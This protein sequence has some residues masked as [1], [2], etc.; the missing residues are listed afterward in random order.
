V[1]NYKI[2]QIVL[3]LAPFVFSFAFGLDIYIP[4]V[5]Q[6]IE[7]FDTSPAMVHL[8]LS[9]F[10]CITGLGQL[11]IGPLSDR[12]GRK[13]TFYLSSICYV[14][15]S[16][17]CALSPH[18]AWLILGRLIC[19]F[20]ACGLLVTSFALI[21]DLYS[22]NDSARMYSFLNGAIGISPT[23]API[24]GGYLSIYLGWQSIFIFLAFIGVLTFFVTW[25]FIGETHGE[26]K[27]IPLDTNI[28]PRYWM[29]FRNRQF[30]L[31]ATIA[32]LAEGVF[33]CFFSI[34]P[35][36]IIDLLG[37]ETQ[38][39]G[40][41][42]AIFGLVIALGGFASGKMIARVGIQSTI[43]SGIIL[44]IAGG[45]CMLSWD[46]F[47]GLSLTGFLF[48]M[49]LACTGAIFAV[50]ACAS[51]ALEPFAPIAGTAAAALGAFE[52]SLS[53]I[54]GALLMLFPVSSTAPY[55][56][57]IVLTGV[58]AFILF[59]KANRIVSSGTREAV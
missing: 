37:I 41:Y 28:F 2:Y 7:I 52:F 56:V 5:P 59:Q 25:R 35:F 33:F 19:G 9:L 47:A 24:I 17:L 15:G 12:Y 58:S 57:I 13:I 27:R 43:F 34:S 44:I 39:F 3:I 40:Y 6:M 4:V 55:G 18:I 20:G 46:H 22:Q 53:S 10:L 23:F 30:L 14:I 49:V 16:V 48:P 11:F 21:R 36:I 26:E 42:F 51:A 50:G 38:N 1:F 31:Y 8:T 54:I 32:G 29:I 45:I